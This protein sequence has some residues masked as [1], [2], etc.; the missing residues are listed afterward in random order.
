MHIF[1][2]LYT[3]IS[4]P[5]QVGFRVS[6]SPAL[7]TAEVLVFLEN[8][9][10]IVINLRTAVIHRN[11]ISRNCKQIFAA[12]HENGFWPDAI[13]VVPLNIALMWLDHSTS[14]P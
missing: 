3:A 1:F 8:I 10:Y 2:I 13:G 6:I 4:L 11:G 12:Y 14:P 9:F 7:L 5:F